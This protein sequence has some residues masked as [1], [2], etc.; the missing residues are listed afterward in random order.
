MNSNSTV[1]LDA[2][3]AQIKQEQAP[4]LAD[5]EF[6]EIFSVQQLLK[7]ADLSIDEI[8]ESIT[9]GTKD[10]G[11]D[12]F[13]LFIDGVY[14]S[15]V[16]E[17]DVRVKKSSLFEV[18]LIQSST[19][20]GFKERKVNS[21][22]ISSN[23]IFN[24]SKQDGDLETRFNS[25]LY[26]KSIQ[27]RK[28]YMK[29]TT[30]FPELK[31]NI[32]YINKSPKKPNRELFDLSRSIEND[33]GELFKNQFSCEFNFID[34]DKLWELTCKDQKQTFEFTASENPISTSERDVMCFVKL[35]EFYNFVTEDDKIIYF[36]FESNVRDYHG[37]VEVNK[38]IRNTLDAGDQSKEDFWWLNNGVT[39]VCTEFKCT[40]PKLTIESPRIVNGL[41]TSHVVFDYFSNS[42]NKLTDNRN[43]LIRIINPEDENSRDRII[44]ATNS[45]TTI[46]PAQLRATDDIQ[47][48]IEKFFKANDLYYDR[49][50]NFYRNQ[51]KPLNKIIGI[52]PLAQ[53]VH[54]ILFEKPHESRAKPS[55]LIKKDEIYKQIFNETYDLNIYLNCARI[56]MEVE[57]F[58][59]QE[60]SKSYSKDL[61]YHLALY[62]TCKK[63]GKSK[64]V[65]SDLAIPNTPAFEESELKDSI[66]ELNDTIKAQ[67]T[68]GTSFNTFLKNVKS[69]EVVRDLISDN[70]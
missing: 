63:V 70:K 55:S 19:E 59:K 10:G 11:I 30:L 68:E 29:N 9:D 26:E 34:V 4:D 37:N 51:G 44:K 53:A 22:K 25:T 56:M 41:Q 40:G 48:D 38:N 27:F 1:L 31:V 33:L 39:I 58:M 13:F 7:N 17:E 2:H 14:I 15:N 12:A 21:I 6:F 8:K 64:I 47:K 54:A 67:L 28:L 62:A 61:K 35:R 18:Y 42:Q 32:F 16:D 36:L 45:Q 43:I 66:K 49:R 65:V 23:L 50:K 5:Q 52:A 57:Q 46:P 3:L 60:E 20:Q 69:T 24:L